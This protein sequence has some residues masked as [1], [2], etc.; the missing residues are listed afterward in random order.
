MRGCII[1]SLETE[2]NLSGKPQTGG[3]KTQQRVINGLSL[4]LF[5]HIKSKCKYNSHLVKTMQLSFE[6]TKCL[7]MLSLH[8]FY[9]GLGQTSSLRP[10]GQDMSIRTS[11]VLKQSSLGEEM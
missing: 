6:E 9:P 10:A 4:I 5:S 11:R 1:N 2:L 7:F 8:C 3:G